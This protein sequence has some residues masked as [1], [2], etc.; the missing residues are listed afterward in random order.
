MPLPLLYFDALV[1]WDGFAE[2]ITVGNRINIPSDGCAA[3]QWG[4]LVLPATTSIALHELTAGYRAS[5][6]TYSGY[7]NT[8]VAK[9]HTCLIIA[10]C[11]QTT[12]QQHI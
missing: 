5:T 4:Y 6:H 7:S 1:H 10:I 8:K 2:L 12:N 11:N 3:G 9:K